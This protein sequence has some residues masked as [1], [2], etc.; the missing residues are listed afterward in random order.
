MKKSIYFRSDADCRI[1]FGHFT[2]T[3]ALAD[4][5]KN[6]FNCIFYTQSPTSYQKI[7]VSKVCKLVELPS[8]ESKF[9]L[10]LS[11]LKGDEIVFLDNY[12]FTP[13]YEKSIKDRGCKL[14]SISPNGRHHYADVLLNMGDDDLSKFDVEPYTK[15]CRGIEWTILRPAFLSSPSSQERGGKVLLYVL[16]A[17][18][19]F[20]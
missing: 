5:L 16:E 1:G 4:I 6:D 3:L 20:V 11:M 18:T 2:R 15:I 17:L 19:N 13:E 12:F 9:D 10:F 14:V 7:E 8:D